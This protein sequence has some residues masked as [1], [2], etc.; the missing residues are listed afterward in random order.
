LNGE[1]DMS[2]PIRNNLRI[3]MS[4]P[5]AVSVFAIGEFNNWST[6]ATP[7]TKAGD[8]EWEF[9]VP[10]DI[11]LE[12]LSFFVV[13]EGARLGRVIDRK[14]LVY[15]RWPETEGSRNW[16]ETAEQRGGVHA[17]GRMSQ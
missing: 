5:S 6:V 2:E 17:F 4:F 3:L 8:D 1:R 15:S 16:G 11:D 13:G 12:H 7:L 10:P 14:R 9:Q